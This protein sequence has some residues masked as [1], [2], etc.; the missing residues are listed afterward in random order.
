MSEPRRG[1][2][3]SWLKLPH[4]QPAYDAVYEVIGRSQ[5]S[6]GANAVIWRAVE[7]AL[8]AMNVPNGRSQ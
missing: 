7:A 2:A 4:R 5:T 3:E 6:V 1:T 8:D